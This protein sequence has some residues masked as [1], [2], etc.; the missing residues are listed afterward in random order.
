MV[1]GTYAALVRAWQTKPGAGNAAHFL[2]GRH[3]IDG[4]TQFAPIT[5]NANHAGGKTHGWW[6]SGARLVHPNTIAV[7][8]ELDNAGRLARAAGRWLHPDSRTTIP[9]ERCL[10]TSTGVAG[11]P[12][13]TTSATRWPSCSRTFRSVSYPA[14]GGAAEW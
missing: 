1:P 8:I 5:R 7:G 12:S 11:T 6:S 4:V 2:I 14:R 13:H 10:S 3:D 9:D